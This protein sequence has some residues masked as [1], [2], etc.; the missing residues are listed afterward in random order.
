M[1]TDAEK[2]ELLQEILDEFSSVIRN[3]PLMYG[4]VPEVNAMIYLYD[5][6]RFVA[7]HGR[8]MDWARC[9]WMTFLGEAGYLKGARNLLLEHSARDPKD[10]TL[11]YKLRDDY[12]KWLET[13]CSG[14]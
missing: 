6:V 12:E 8:K 10:F 3:R 2:L 1:T 13:R 11:F 5:S 14:S 9:S 4:T 7:R